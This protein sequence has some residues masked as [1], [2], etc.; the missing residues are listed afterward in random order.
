M[1]KIA[2]KYLAPRQA[3]AFEYF[4]YTDMTAREVGAIMNIN[5][6]GAQ[7]LK[8][9]ARNKLKQYRDEIR[10]ELLAIG[11]NEAGQ[12]IAEAI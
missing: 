6:N 3:E 7:S 9:A 8:T 10:A 4:Y 12:E 2:L 1:K 11:L 5:I